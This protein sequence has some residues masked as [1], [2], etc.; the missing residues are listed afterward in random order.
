MKQNTSFK[1]AA[2]IAAPA[3]ALSRRQLLG[4]MAA[5]ATAVLLAKP[6]ALAAILPTRTIT[7]Q[8]MGAFEALRIFQQIS[9]RKR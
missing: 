3:A 7:A 9:A 8:K 5:S 2:L 6:L 4:G 1:Q